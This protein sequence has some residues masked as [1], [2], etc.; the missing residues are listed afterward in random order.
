MTGKLAGKTA[1]VTGSTRGLGRTTA[2]WLAREGANVVVSGRDPEAVASSVA[3]VESYGV[4]GWGIAA[5]LAI[6]SE[7]HRLGEET[8]ATVP[9]LDILVN[10]AGMSIQNDFWKVSDEEWDIQVNANWRSSFILAQHAARHMIGRKIE[11][12]IVNTSTIG[13]R[14]CHTDRLVYDASK[15]AIETMTRNMA[16]ELAPY[17]I[18][19]NCVAPGNMAE[20][21]GAEE[22]DWWPAATAR[23]PFGRLGRA[24]DISAAVLFFCLPE[25]AFTTGQTLLVDGAHNTYLPEF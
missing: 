12:R 19:V 16:Y 4:Q 17:G 22:A 23:I 14:A 18:S 21:P 10:N 8:L 24:E 25:T 9:Q 13:A 7:A 15:G 3:A 20:R 11:G 6:V 1:L 2:E 5:D